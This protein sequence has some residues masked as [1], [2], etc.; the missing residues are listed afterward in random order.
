MNK[1]IIKKLY[2]D[3]EISL[4]TEVSIEFRI[5]DSSFC[6]GTVRIHLPAPLNASWLLEGRLIDSD[7]FFR[8]MSVEDYPQRSAY[9]NEILT[10]NKTFSIGYGFTSVHKYIKPDISLIDSV[11][12]KTFDPADIKRFLELSHCGCESYTALAPDAV[13]IKDVASSEGLPF[14]DEHYSFLS[15]HGIPVP[16]HAACSSG[17]SFTPDAITKNSAA[18][19]HATFSL[20]PVK[21]NTITENPTTMNKGTL[22]RRLFDLI[23]EEYTPCAN[24]TLS[25]AYVSICRMCGIPARWQGGYASADV[26]YPVSGSNID[27][28]IHGSSI[29][30]P[31]FETDKITSDNNNNI[32]TGIAHDWCLIHLLPYGWIYADP[33]Y[34]RDFK[35]EF[36]T[37]IDHAKKDFKDY[38][39]GNIDPFMVPTATE[40]SANLYPAKDYERTDKIFNVRGEAELIPGKMNGTGHFDGRGLT[41][42]EFE[43]TVRLR[44]V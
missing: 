21:S 37:D 34:A 4:E 1:T 19:D 5:K 2:T 42:D 20:N 9:F 33:G 8:M 40:P 18:V 25:M 24:E 31:G 17:Q 38:F 30:S 44:F 3:G 41:A 39:F 29:Y 15:E 28:N 16:A 36:I 23:I 10:E 43:T 26:I 6:P 32:Y 14:R 27:E 35:D 12:Q 7:P 13:T 11:S 22:A